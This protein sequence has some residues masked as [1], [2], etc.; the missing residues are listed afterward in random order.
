[1][2]SLHIIDLF[3]FFFFIVGG[4]IVKTWSDVITSEEHPPTNVRL[5][6]ATFAIILILYCKL[7]HWIVF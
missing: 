4:A 6:N 7:V 1:M 2:S 5:T 3:G